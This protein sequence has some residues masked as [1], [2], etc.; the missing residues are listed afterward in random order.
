VG[1]YA[2]GLDMTARDLQQKAKE[3]RHPW[4]VAKGFDTFAPLG[5]LAPADEVGDPQDLTL[6]LSVNDTVR[7][8]ATTA[9]MVF[10]VAELVH[11]CSTIFT[12][13]PGDLIYTGTPEGVGPVA[14]GDVVQARSSA[15]APLRVRVRNEPRDAAPSR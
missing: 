3:R 8:Q 4:S 2:L 10:P 9:D 15:C 7:Q 11:Y 1:A 6:Q 14:E 5:P 13:R 12:L